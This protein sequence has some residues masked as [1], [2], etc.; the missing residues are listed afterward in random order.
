MN[1]CKALVLAS[2]PLAVADIKADVD[3]TSKSLGSVR[4]N[5]NQQNILQYKKKENTLTL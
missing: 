4:G 5:F 1:V 2:F 3:W